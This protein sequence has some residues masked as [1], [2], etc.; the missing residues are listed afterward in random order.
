MNASAQIRCN[1]GALLRRQL[2]GR[3]IF[4]GIVRAVH[5][6]SANELATLGRRQM[7]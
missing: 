6:P 3:H 7:H 1:L 2:H 4:A 5:A